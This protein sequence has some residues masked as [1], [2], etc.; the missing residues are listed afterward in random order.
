MSVLLCH[1]KHME[2]PLELPVRTESQCQP[3]Y[4]CSISLIKRLI[5]LKILAAVTHCE[6]E[7]WNEEYEA[8]TFTCSHQTYRSRRGKKTPRKNGYFL[9][10]WEKDSNGRNIP[11]TANDFSDYLLVFVIDGDCQGYFCFP[12]KELVQRGILSSPGK[13]GKMAF[14]IYPSWCCGLNTSAR[15]TQAWQVR[16]FHPVSPVTGGR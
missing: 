13:K 7:R 14:R 5:D 8:L 15:R 4:S 9:T 6:K 16:Y 12:R 3:V 1:N 10:L 11:F 2:K